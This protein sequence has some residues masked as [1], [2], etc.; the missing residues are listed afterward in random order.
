MSW[1]AKETILILGNIV[2]YTL[3]MSISAEKVKVEN[4][5]E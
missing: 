3:T 1:I 2:C 5:Y 4:M